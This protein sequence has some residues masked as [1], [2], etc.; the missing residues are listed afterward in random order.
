M[1]YP[2]FSEPGFEDDIEDHPGRHSGER[3]VLIIRFK[4]TTFTIIKIDTDA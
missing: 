1:I 3:G 2:S 4:K